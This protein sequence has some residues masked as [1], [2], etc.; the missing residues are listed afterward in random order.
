MYGTLHIFRRNIVNGSPSFQINYTFAGR[1]FARVV[2][3]E[4]ELRNF[5][6]ESAALDPHEID[7]I[8]GQLISGSAT[9]SDVKMSDNEAVEAGMNE[10]PSD[11]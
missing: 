3:S 10:S 11:F 6:L 7:S 4:H 1:S 2:H 8:C 9:I 5:I